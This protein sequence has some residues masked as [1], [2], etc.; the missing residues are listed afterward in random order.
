K[1]WDVVVS[2]I[3]DASGKPDRL[4]A[5][6]RDVTEHRTNETALCEALQFNREIIEGAA[7]GIIV[8]DSELR[9]QL[10]N[11]YMERLTGKRSEEVL[12]RVAIEVFPRLGPSGIEAALRLALR[13]EVV[14]VADVLVPKHS[15]DGRDLWESCTFG[16]HRDAQ[17][18]VIGVIGLVRDITER[19]LAEETF[20]SIVIGTASATGSDFFPSLVRRL[21]TALRVRYA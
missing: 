14:Q 5:L 3:Y 16:P 7:E 15:A 19:H 6:T 9:Y 12:G 8:Y 11:P 13:G 10:F 4:L 21:A 20:R 17:G 18:K 2:P 1:W